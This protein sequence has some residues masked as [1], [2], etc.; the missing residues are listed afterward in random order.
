RGRLLCRSFC[1]CRL[2]AGLRRTT[3]AV[4]AGPRSLGLLPLL[5][6]PLRLD[7]LGE[8]DDVAFRVG[9]ERIDE[10][11]ACVHRLHHPA[12]AEA[13]GLRE[14]RTWIV[15]LDIKRHEASAVLARAD[16]AR[17]ARA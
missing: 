15:G 16:G 7:H 5:L 1:G 3:V 9:E 10:A 12:A 11:L 14:Q 6:L 4:R 8:T 13:L 17:D 2:G